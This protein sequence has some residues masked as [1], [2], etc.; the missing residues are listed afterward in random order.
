MLWKSCELSSVLNVESEV[1]KWIFN[2]PALD[3]MS[4]AAIAAFSESEPLIF[5]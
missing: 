3:E 4:V 2:W 1:A 5:L